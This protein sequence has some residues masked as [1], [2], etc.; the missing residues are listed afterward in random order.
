MVVVDGFVPEGHFKLAHTPKE[1]L[2]IEATFLCARNAGF[3]TTSLTFVNGLFI[4]MPR[5]GSEAIAELISRRTTQLP[6]TATMAHV[7][8]T[9]NGRVYTAT[10]DGLYWASRSP[11]PEVIMKTIAGPEPPEDV[12]SPDSDASVE[13]G[14]YCCLS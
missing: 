3:D 11:Q 4:E 13:T 5:I 14:G 8:I 7:I 10:V 1:Q 6:S 9:W 12:A 2:L